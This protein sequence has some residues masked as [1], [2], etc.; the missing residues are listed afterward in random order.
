MKM[1]IKRMALHIAAVF[2]ILT[3]GGCGGYA[4]QSSSGSGV[5]VY[6][7]VDAG[8]SHGTR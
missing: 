6:G 3:I 2:M 4:Q 5:Q 1:N 8:I 7:T